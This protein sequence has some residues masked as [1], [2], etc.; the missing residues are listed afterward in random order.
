M[1][2]D[3]IQAQL[4][5]LFAA[6]AQRPSRDDV[7]RL[8]ETLLTFKIGLGELRD[9]LAATERELTAARADLETYQRRGRQA[10][11][12]GDDETVRV[13]DEFTARA[14]ERVDLLERKVV[15]QRDEVAMADRDYAQARERFDAA[16]RGV[17]LDESAGGPASDE[18]RGLDQRARD[19][20]VDAQLEHLK[21]KLGK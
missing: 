4:D 9:A 12:I 15:V 13:A 16:Q 17:P 5:R 7:R 2:L 1:D 11:G 19:A 21:K 8:R 10:A 3:A 18:A 14:R 6:R 20:A